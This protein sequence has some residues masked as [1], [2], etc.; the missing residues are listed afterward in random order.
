MSSL[1]LW[2]FAGGFVGV[3][4]GLT[5]WRTVSRLSTNAVTR[6]LVMVLGGMF[7]RLSLVTGLLMAGLI[8]GIVPGLLAFVGIWITRWAIVILVSAQQ[9]PGEP[10]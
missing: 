2:P 9:G 5:R 4:N 1:W 6:S 7:L 8:R 3:L 10:C